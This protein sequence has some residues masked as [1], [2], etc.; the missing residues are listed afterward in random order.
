MKYLFD[1]FAL[2]TD[3]FELTRGA[4]LVAVEPQVFHLLRLLVESR[5]QLLSKDQIID[6]VWEGRAVSDSSVSNA[7]KLARE[8]VDDD[9]RKQCRIRT[10]HGQGFRFVAEVRELASTADCAVPVLAVEPEVAADRPIDSGKPS[11]AVLPFQFL[12]PETSSAIYADA[13][14]YDLIQALSRLRW[15]MVIA[16]GST[17]RFRAVGEDPVAI[18]KALGVRYL[19]AGTVEVRGADIIVTTELCDT[20]NGAIIWSERFAGASRNVHEIQADIVNKVV[21]SLEI[22][23]PLV[24]AS[25]ARLCGSE[26]LD[27]W[28][29]YHLGLQ[30]MYRFNQADNEA[31]STH[32]ERA[33][34]QDPDFARAHAGLSFTYFQTAFLRYGPSRKEALQDSR[35]QAERGVDLDPL[36]PFVNFA[37]G[38]SLMLQG[39]LENSTQWLGRAITLNP[40]Y[41]QGHY[42][43]AFA[44]FLGGQTE[45]SFRHVDT[46]LELS[47]LDPLLYAMRAARALSLVIDED[48]EDAELHAEEAARTPGA[49]YLIDMIALIACSLNGSRERAERWAGH[50]RKRRPDANQSLFFASFPFS[51]DTLR[52]RLAGALARY[53]F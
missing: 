25:R 31:A 12:G 43:H 52:K 51:S 46:A 9:G 16:R 2:D 32:F 6:S 10:V 11:I 36:D 44:D 5:E 53:D 17:F 49:H 13:I 34:A 14:P 42:S 8:A 22:H 21:S 23:I 1:G 19:M 30:Y 38:R 26:N 7:I 4:D 20:Q 40:N 48:Y 33:I 47:P 45:A 35:K 27:S 3:R 41:S 50:I 24:E 18:G 28:A 15:L 39:E 37:M 29:N